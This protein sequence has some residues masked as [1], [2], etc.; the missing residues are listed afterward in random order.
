M[1]AVVIGGY[2]HIGRHLVP[3]L[4][5]DGYEVAVVTR[6]RQ[7]RPDAASWQGL[8]VEHLK[9]DYAQ[10]VGSPA[11]IKALTEREPHVVIDILGRD[12]PALTDALPP[13][14]EHV[15]LC[16]WLWMF[17]MITAVRYG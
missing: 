4:S 11:G 17:L 2:G 15:V 5:A 13:T 9:L 1:N 8:S 14:V 12:T 7:S 3:K 10:L 6:G 16:G